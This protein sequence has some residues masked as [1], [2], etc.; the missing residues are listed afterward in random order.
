MSE[1]ILILLLCLWLFKQNCYSSY[2]QL[3]KALH[4]AVTRTHYQLAFSW[5]PEKKTRKREELLLFRESE[6]LFDRL[7]EESAVWTH[8]SND[9]HPTDDIKNEIFFYPYSYHI[10]ARQKN[11]RLLQFPFCKHCCCFIGLLPGEATYNNGYVCWWSNKIRESG[12]LELELQHIIG[13]M[14]FFCLS[15]LFMAINTASRSFTS[16]IT[17]FQL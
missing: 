5:C 6:C 17:L 13:A 12:V 15:G 11:L 16:F 3:M 7:S 8:L 4:I 1:G 10:R 2:I 9:W 14:C